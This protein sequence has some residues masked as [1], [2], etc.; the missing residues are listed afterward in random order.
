M[1]L[2]ALALTG[3]VALLHQ[4]PI[5]LQIEWASEWARLIHALT[6]P[7][8]VGTVLF[9]VGAIMRYQIWTRKR[10]RIHQQE[11]EAKDA[12]IADLQRQVNEQNGKSRV[13]K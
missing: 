10:A 11:L 9:T 13:L 6:E 2:G 1:W 12:V 7:S 5:V 3:I 4:E 8:A